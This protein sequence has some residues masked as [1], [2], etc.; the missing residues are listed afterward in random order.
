MYV[1]D[2]QTGRLARLRVTYHPP[3][4]LWLPR[5]TES[6]LTCRLAFA[7]YLTFPYLALP[8]LRASY[9]PPESLPRVAIKLLEVS[10]H[11]AVGPS[12]AA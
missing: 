5:L 8:A 4:C 6:L 10:R 3:A 2:W 1:Q 12:L 7:D 11:R 9:I